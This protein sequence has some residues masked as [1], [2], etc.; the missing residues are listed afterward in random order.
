MKQKRTQKR[1]KGLISEEST[2]AGTKGGNLDS[3]N[4]YFDA[5]DD[6][7][8][9]VKDDHDDADEDG[10]TQQGSS[11]MKSGKSTNTGGIDSF[12]APYFQLLHLQAQLHQAMQENSKLQELLKQ[13]Q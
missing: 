5:I 4:T 12:E 6:D 1:K 10:N 9:N 11:Q 8:D 13:L 2:P 7:A 3:A